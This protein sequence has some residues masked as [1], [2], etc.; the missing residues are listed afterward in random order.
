[1]PAQCGRW[2][3]RRPGGSDTWTCWKAGIIALSRQIAVQCGRFGIRSNVVAPGVT[4]AAGSRLAI[5]EPVTYDAMLATTA[6]GRLGTPVD[7]ANSVL[8]LASDESSFVTGAVLTVDG[9]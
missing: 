1:M 2:W 7:Q 9:G 3:A 4:V 8:F 6:L 5:E